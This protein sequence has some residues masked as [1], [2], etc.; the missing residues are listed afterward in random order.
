[1]KEEASKHN[2]LPYVAGFA[3]QVGVSEAHVNHYIQK[4]DWEGLLKSLL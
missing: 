4:K 1:M 3:Q 2:L